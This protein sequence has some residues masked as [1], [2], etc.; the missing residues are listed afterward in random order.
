MDALYSYLLFLAETITIA[1]AVI[2]IIVVAASLSQKNKTEDGEIEVTKLNKRFASI[3]Q[4]LQQALLSKEDFKALQKE[5]KQQAKHEPEAQEKS[6]TFVIDFHGDIKASD[7]ENLRECVTAALM[8]AEP[9]DT[10]FVRLESAGGMVHSYGLAASQ[11]QRIKDSHI[12]LVISVDKVAASGGYLMACVADK[13]LAAPFAIIGSIGVLAQIPNFNR[14][15]KENNIDFE[16]HTAGE[17]KRTLTVFGENTDEG[18]VK[19]KQEIN[20]A[21]D[22]FKSHIASYRT[23]LD[24][25]KVATGEHWYGSKALELGLIDE[26]KTSDDYLLNAAKESDLFLIEYCAKKT[27]K[28]KLTNLMQHAVNNAMSYWQQKQSEKKFD[29]IQY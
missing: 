7:V 28:D 15:L 19:L 4:T 16:Q 24:I 1:A 8:V 29:Q 25:G 17:Y 2:A 14:L 18:R 27:I 6:K 3:K 22:L 10:V 20:E 13:I 26:I 12:N 9:K 11:L 5:K 21:H 23:E